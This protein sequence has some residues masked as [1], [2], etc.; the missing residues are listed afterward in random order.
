MFDF[1]QTVV[2]SACGDM[3]AMGQGC[4]HAGAAGRA[5]LD[6]ERR[7]HWPVTLVYPEVMQRDAVEDWCED[8]P[9]AAQLVAMFGPDAP[10]LQWDAG[11]AHH[12]SAD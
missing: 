3:D 10:P 6:A 9:F 7:V 5:Y 11:Q 12:P 2:L 4:M 8:T 1:I